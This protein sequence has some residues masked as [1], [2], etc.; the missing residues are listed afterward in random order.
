[1][2]QIDMF[3]LPSPQMV[4]HAAIN[5]YQDSWDGRDGLGMILGS[6]HQNAEA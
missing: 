4:S 6:Q 5:L 2:S 1:M 3:L